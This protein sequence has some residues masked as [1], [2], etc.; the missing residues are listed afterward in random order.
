MSK[1]VIPL[2]AALAAQKKGDA[3][4][5]LD[6]LSTADLCE[7]DGR[8]TVTEDDVRR[9]ERLAEVSLLRREVVR[10]SPH[11]KVLLESV[12][13]KEEKQSP[14][15]VYREFNNIMRLS[16]REQVSHKTL[17]VL[18]AELEL[19][20]LVEVERKGR[21]RG[22][23]VDFYIYPTGSVERKALLDALKDLVV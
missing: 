18:V 15:E 4:Y 7:E 14:T 17:S 11:Q 16:G 1:E 9:A 5:A 12:Y 6:L 8:T 10:L 3:R 20:G 22:R 2:C 13:S 21:C 23:G 19:S